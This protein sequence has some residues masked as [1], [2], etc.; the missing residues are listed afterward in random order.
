MLG[1]YRDGML[2]FSGQHEEVLYCPAAVEGEERRL[3]RIDTMDLGFPL[4]LEPE[5]GQFLQPHRIALNPGDTLILYTDGITEAEDESG[6]FFGVERLT[7]A[8]LDQIDEPVQTMHDRIVADLY[9]H[10]G[11]RQVYDD[12]TL[13]VLRRGP[14]G[15]A[16]SG[17]I[18]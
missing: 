9:A 15:E 5:I 18:T 17:A 4:G 16:V 2:T 3:E 6:S 1:Y 10:I 8:I 7:G 11:S 12:I 13:M 14:G